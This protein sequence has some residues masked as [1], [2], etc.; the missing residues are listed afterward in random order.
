MDS[1][2]LEAFNNMNDLWVDMD[3]LF[4]KNPWGDRGLDSPAL[5]MAFMACYNVDKFRDFVFN[6]SFLSRFDVN[7]DRMEKIQSDDATLLIFGF[8]WVRFFLTGKGPLS[9]K[10]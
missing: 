6:S 5:K 7:K 2:E 3:T 4:R 8:D 9:P 1:Q 10:A